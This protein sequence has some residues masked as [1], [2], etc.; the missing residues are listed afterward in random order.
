MSQ[1]AEPDPHDRSAS[2]TAAHDLAARATIFVTL[3]I[4]RSSGV[5]VTTIELGNGGR[6]S[7]AAPTDGAA[8]S[9]TDTVIPAPPPPPPAS[10]DDNGTSEGTVIIVVV[11]LFVL[12]FLFLGCCV[13][14][15]RRKG[16]YFGLCGWVGPRGRRGPRGHQGEQGIPVCF[17][18]TNPRRNYLRELTYNL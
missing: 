13:C 2:P 16:A 15:V 17:F 14:G 5:H 8:A 3:T 9:P 10:S 11:V 1:L 7:A 6:D 12:F 18:F 4:T